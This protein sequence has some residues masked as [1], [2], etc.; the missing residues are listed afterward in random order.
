MNALTPTEQINA[1][2]R[3]RTALIAKVARLE[4]DVA[5]IAMMTGVDLTQKETEEDAKDED[6]E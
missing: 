1:L 2:R 3:E 5:Y 6:E 4:A